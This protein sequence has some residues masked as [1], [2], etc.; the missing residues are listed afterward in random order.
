M[1]EDG[2]K[3]RYGFDTTAQSLVTMFILL[4]GDLWTDIMHNTVSS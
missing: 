1:D 3:T 2:N 4:T